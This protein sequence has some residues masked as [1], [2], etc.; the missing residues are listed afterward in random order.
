MDRQE[1]ELELRTIIDEYL[2][3]QGI[4][5]VDFIC[6][7]EGRDLV[8]RILADRPQGGITLDDCAYL[9]SEIGVMLDEKNI[10]QEH[11][12]LEV[13]SPGLDR[14]LRSKNDF[15]RSI[16]KTAKF[17]L[18]EKINGK[19]EFDGKITGVTDTSVYIEIKGE[20]IEIPLS[21]ITKGKLVF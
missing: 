12:I 19:M 14:P 7:Y 8:L 3:S 10:L 9:N 11:Y 18:N 15:L 6:R 21:K 16:N 1:R 17:F 20:K 2:K 13:A 4:E 5:L